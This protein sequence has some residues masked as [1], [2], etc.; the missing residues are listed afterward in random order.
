VTEIETTYVGEV[1]KISRAVQY[2]SEKGFSL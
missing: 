1:L 2:Y